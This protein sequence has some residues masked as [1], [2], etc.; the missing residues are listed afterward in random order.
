MKP[1]LALAALA[2]AIALSACAADVAIDAQPPVSPLLSGEEFYAERDALTAIVRDQSPRQALAELRRKTGLD[3]RYAATCHDL[4]HEIGRE[5]IR[6]QGGFAEA[7]VFADEICNSG[8]M[9]GIIEIAF[10]RSRDIGATMNTICEGLPEKRF[11]AWE[12]FHGVGHGLMFESQ[13]D[14]PGSIALCNTYSTQFRRKACAN[15]VYMENFNADAVL[16]P[17]EY[18]D[19]DNPLS[20]CSD[21]PTEHRLDCY[22][23]APTHYLSLHEGDYAGALELCEAVAIQA[24]FACIRGVGMQAM[25]EH[26]LDPADALAI[27]DLPNAKDESACIAGAIGLL[28]NHH[29]SPIPARAVCAALDEARMDPCLKEISA[30]AVLFEP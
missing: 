3:E 12:C 25:K 15:G 28:V 22:L 26:V 24:R 2:S 13:N 1:R 9:H 7:M 21:Q 11:A 6:A 8:Y 4:A 27:C 30:V 14:M 20:P 10:E 29:G 17:S 23:Y 5:A 16:H 19:V 18:V